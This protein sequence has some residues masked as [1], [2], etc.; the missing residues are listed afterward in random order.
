MFKFI[1]AATAALT[2]AAP[3]AAA[4]QEAPSYA[5]S[6]ASADEQIRGRVVAFDGAYDLTV[7]DERGFDDNV[8]LH[9]GTIINPTG[10]TLAPGMVVSVIGYN[11]GQDLAANEI[12]TPYD[13]DAGVPYFGGHAWNYYGPSIDLGFFF[14]NTGW[15]HG[16]DFAG[17]YHYDRGERVYANIRIDSAR[18]DNRRVDVGYSRPVAATRFSQPAYR[19]P[20]QTYRTTAP[21][22][23]TTQPAYR[24]TAPAYRSAPLAGPNFRNAG[25]TAPSNPARSDAGHASSADDHHR[26]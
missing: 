15:W 20:E 21:A 24:T 5:Q 18:F 17:A 1:L 10:L 16:N 6:V 22:F 2:L 25:R 12:D 26:H 14:G 3:L 4:A 11:E 8:A 19:A 13:V 7:R 23:H 9:P